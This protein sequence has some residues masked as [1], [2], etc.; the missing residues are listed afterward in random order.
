MQKVFPHEFFRLDFD[1]ILQEGQRQEEIHP[2]NTGEYSLVQGMHG[3]FAD[4]VLPRIV[5]D[6]WVFGAAERFASE[7]SVQ[8]FR[9]LRLGG[10]EAYRTQQRL[11]EIN[12]KVIDCLAQAH[13][14]GWA[15]LAG[16]I[17]LPK[18]SDFVDILDLDRMDPRTRAEILALRD[19]ARDHEG[20]QMTVTLRATR[21]SYETNVTRIMFVVRRA[22]KVALGLP[23]K[24]TDDTLLSPSDY[25][26]WYVTH[27]DSNHP[28]YPVLGEGRRFY[29]VARNVGS[30]HIGLEWEPGTDMVILR[31]RDATISMHMHAFQQ[32]YRHLIHFCDLGVR[33]ILAAFCEREHGDVS[34]ALVKE[35]KKVF[36]P[37]WTQG[38]ER[39]V[40]S[41]PVAQSQEGAG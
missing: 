37:G 40:I 21:D 14:R 18:A 9:W 38:E 22:M 35:Y 1:Q 11:H 17:S 5:E 33:G 29:K 34:N 39:K 30:H 12:A 15:P 16:T 10:Q 26:D 24:S 32:S 2:A 8:C 20:I 25:I 31:D 4:D 3:F 27:A 19:E 41:Y 13:M 36:P 7:Y 23:K 6:D 28:L